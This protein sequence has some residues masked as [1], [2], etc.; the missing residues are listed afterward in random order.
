ML[1][2]LLGCFNTPAL[3]INPTVQGESESHSVVSNSLQP[4]GLYYP[5]NSPGQNPGVCSFS[6]LQGIFEP[7]SLTLQ[8]DSLPAELSK[9]GGNLSIDKNNSY[10]GLKLSNMFKSV[11]S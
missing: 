7:R 11:N 3:V 6:L 9:D 10:N 4:Q 2:K 5:W 8:L 1:Q